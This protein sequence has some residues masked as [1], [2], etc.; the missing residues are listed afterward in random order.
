MARP[1][2][3]QEPEAPSGPPTRVAGK[4]VLESPAVSQAQSR[5]AE[6]EAEQLGLELALI[7]LLP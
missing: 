7:A 4:Q 5:A 6:W 3:N 1:N 2:Q